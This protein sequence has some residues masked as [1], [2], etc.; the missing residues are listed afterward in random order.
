MR[1]AGILSKAML[2]CEE[3]STFIPVLANGF[4]RHTA[5]I[6]VKHAARTVGDSKYSLWRL[7]NLTVRPFDEHDDFSAACFERGGHV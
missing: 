2:N 7:I 1:I 4:A 6:E 3:R 5:E